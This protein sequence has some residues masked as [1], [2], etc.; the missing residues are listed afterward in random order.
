MI[1]SMTGFG[2]SEYTD[3]KRNITVEIKS[4]NHRFNDITVKMPRRYAFAEDRIKAIVKETARRGKIEVSIMIESI[5][6]DDVA[7]RLN[8]PA[9][10]R[11]YE[12]LVELKRELSLD[13]EITVSLLASMP[14][15]LRTVS[16][17]EEEDEVIKSLSIPVAA[18]ALQLNEMRIMEGNELAKDIMMRGTHILDL[19]AIIRD[20]A[21]VM[22]TAYADKLRE[23]ICE[24]VKGVIEVPEDRILLEAAI[25]A[26]KASITE[27]V[28]RLESHVLQ[29]HKILAES[30]QP[31]GK[32]LDFLV[33]EMNREANTIGSKANDVE[34]TNQVIEMKSEIEKIR[35]QVQNI[36]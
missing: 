27:E 31:D 18:A 16:D 14:D 30:N 33:Q 23:R 9:A 19:S 2:R 22:A 3:G 32:K 10:K 35:E 28:V 13:G 26:D 20:R 25:F 36:E 8:T 17:I 24:L 21:P 4:V 29:L 7:V 34:V 6:G 1:K 15:V 12:N 11:Y 5:A